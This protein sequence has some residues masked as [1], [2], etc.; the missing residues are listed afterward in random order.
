MKLS[1]TSDGVALVP[2]GEQ[3]AGPGHVDHRLHRARLVV[4]RADVPAGRGAGRAQERDQVPAG[5]LSPGADLGG[6]D[7]EA[8]GVGA[9]IADGALHVLDLVRPVLARPE[10]VVEADHHEPPVGQRR[11]DAVDDEAARVVVARDPRTPV[12]V[13]RG[14]GRAVQRGRLGDQRLLVVAVLDFGLLARG[15]GRPR[16]GGGGGG[17]AAA[18]GGVELAVVQAAS[19]PMPRRQMTADAEPLRMDINVAPSGAGGG[20]RPG[21]ALSS[22]PGS[23][24]VRPGSAREIRQPNVEG[25]SAPG[26]I[27]KT[28]NEFVDSF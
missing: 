11:A 21:S 22:G 1:A 5:A 28:I 20:F 3:V 8:V 10:P 7:V 12:D 15:Q 24:L 18:W 14:R 23:A 19:A 26:I 13:D 2:H 17:R 6:V 25:L 4:V 16:C 9:Q 27:L